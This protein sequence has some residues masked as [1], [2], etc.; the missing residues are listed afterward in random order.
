MTMYIKIENGQ[1]VGHPLVAQNMWYLFPDFN[2]NRVITSDMVS[3]LGYSIYEFT[4]MPQ[5]TRYKKV[6]EVTPE[7]NSSNGIYYQ[8][9][10][11]VDMTD[12]EK[13][14]V[15]N[16]QN[17]IARKDRNLRLQQTDWVLLPDSPLTE[18]QKQNFILYRQQLRDIPEQ[19]GFP[20]DISWPIYPN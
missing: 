18:S 19:S 15:D 9:W 13:T 6:I 12:E 14:A 7:L 4:Q 3:E 1:P 17:V 2:W 5:P 11:I 10:Q 8:K 16:T 20:W